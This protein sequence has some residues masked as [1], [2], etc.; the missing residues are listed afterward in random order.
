M[1]KKN[2]LIIATLL[3]LA[4]ASEP[5]LTQSESEYALIQ[6]PVFKNP[7]IWKMTRDVTQTYWN[8]RLFSSPRASAQSYIMTP[9]HELYSAV[10]FTMDHSWN[11]MVYFECLDSWIRAYGSFG[12]ETCQFWWPRG[13][14]V[15]APFDDEYAGFYY[16]VYIADTNNDR[17]VRLRYDWQNQLMICDNPITGNGLSY[18]YDLDLNDNGTFFPPGDDYLWVLDDQARI[19]RFSTEGVLYSTFSSYYGC[20]GL[21]GQFC[22]LTAIASGRSPFL[23]EPYDQYANN[24][25]LYVADPGN[26]RIVWLIKMTGGEMIQWIAETPATSSV[27]DLE[28]DSFGQ[29]WALDQDNG[30]ITKYTYDLFPLCT[31][32]SSGT[33]ENQFFKPISIST[34]GGYLGCGDMYVVESWSDS[35]GGQFFAIGTDVLNFEVTSSENQ[36]EHYINYILIDFSDVVVEVRDQSNVLV[37]TLF[38]GGQVSGTCSFVWEGTDN[39]DQPVTSGSYRVVL[40]DSCIYWNVVDSTPVNVVTK[41]VWFSHVQP[42]CEIRGDVDHSG[43]MDV[44]DMT[45]L[46]A[47]LFFGGPPPPC[48][49]EGDVDGSGGINVADLTYLVA[50]LFLGGPPPD[51]C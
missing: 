46:V 24:D 17:I 29:L 23:T 12:H 4:V 43:G 13:I 9:W 50:Y 47:R 41:E 39:S 28:V 16:Y 1:R 22:R 44:A 27:V 6:Q 2:I 15:L 35:S 10:S 37:K 51:G 30:V 32:G 20:D 18:P 19:K 42:C 21:P 8:I 36:N 48:E 38:D 40:V 14:D 7:M 31:F 34:H 33:G 11:R 5:G 49:D 25:H 45:Y 26:N 3:L